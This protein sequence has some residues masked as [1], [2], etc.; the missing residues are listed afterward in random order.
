MKNIAVVIDITHD[1]GGKENMSLSVCSHLSEI[2]QFNF[3]YITTYYKTKK[4]LENKLGK[5]ILLY[6]KR[7]FL[8]RLNNRLKKIFS[9]LPIDYPFQRFLLKKK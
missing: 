2:K 7:N 9:F 6:N 5:K 1:S 3:I 4:I 8:K